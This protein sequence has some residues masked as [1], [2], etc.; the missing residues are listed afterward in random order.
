[1]AIYAEDKYR[2][3]IGFNSECPITPSEFSTW[4]KNLKVFLGPLKDYLEKS[5]SEIVSVEFIIQKPHLFQEFTNL[6]NNP[7][8]FPGPDRLASS[9]YRPLYMDWVIGN[10]RQVAFN[11]KEGLAYKFLREIIA[12]CEENRAKVWKILCDTCHKFYGDIL[13]QT[14]GDAALAFTMMEAR[15]ALTGDAM[16]ATI[17]ARNELR[18]LK[19]ASDGD[20]MENLTQFSTR[21]KQLMSHIATLEGRLFQEKEMIIQF[22]EGLPSDLANVVNEY[23]LL[24][25]NVTFSD[26][27]QRL[28]GF[29]RNAELRKP[30][31]ETPL[32]FLSNQQQQNEQ[33]KPNWKLPRDQDNG[34]GKEFK[35]KMKRKF[36][37]NDNR[38]FQ[39]HR[40]YHNNHHYHRDYHQGHQSFKPK[41]K[42]QHDNRFRND[43]RNGNPRY[44]NGPIGKFKPFPRRTKMR[45]PLRAAANRVQSLEIKYCNI[46]DTNSHD[47]EHCRY[48]L[49]RE[50]VNNNLN[51]CYLDSFANY[52]HKTGEVDKVDEDRFNFVLDSGSTDTHTNNLENLS[53]IKQVKLP[54]ATANGE[55]EYSTAIGEVNSLKDVRYTPSFKENLLSINSLIDLD[56]QVIFS[57]SGSYA[58]LKNGDDI[59]RNVPIKRYNKLYYID[60]RDL[61]DNQSKALL[62]STKPMNNILTWHQRLH[63]SNDLIF[64]L[65]EHHATGINLK[66]KKLNKQLFG[67]ISVCEAC[68]LARIRKKVHKHK[69]RRTFPSKCLE[70]IDVDLKQVKV[71]YAGYKYIMAMKCARSKFTWIFFLKTKDEAV[72]KLEYFKAYVLTKFVEDP[73]KTEVLFRVRQI[74]TDGGGEFEKEFKDACL[75]Y[76]IAHI[77]VPAYSQYL[78]SY[79]ESYWRTLMELTR[80]FLKHAD[81]SDFYWPWACLYA[82]HILNRCLLHPIDKEVKTSYE[83]LY[84]VKPDLSKIRTFGCEIYRHVPLEKRDNKALSDWGEKGKFFG[85]CDNMV[86]GIFVLTPQNAVVEENYDF[87]VF[88]EIIMPRFHINNGKDISELLAEDVDKDM[89]EDKAEAEAEK[90][91]VVK[92]RKRISR[93]R[94][95]E[96]VRKSRRLI[97]KNR[98]NNAKDI[99][100]NLNDVDISEIKRILSKAEYYLLRK[101]VKRELTAE[102]IWQWLQAIGKEKA[103]IA[104]NNVFELVMRPTNGTKIHGTDW[105]FDIKQDPVSLLELFK[106]ARL[107]F[108]GDR[109]KEGIDYFHTFA[110]VAKLSSLRIFLAIVVEF[111]MEM[112][113]GDVRTAFLNAGLEEELFLEIPLFYSIDEFINVLEDNDPLKKVHPSQ[114][115]LKLKKA[116]YGLK[117]APRNWFENIVNFILQLGFNACTAEPCLFYKIIGGDRIIIFLYV[118]DFIIAATNGHHLL[119]Y[120][121]MIANRYDIKEIGKPKKILGISIQYEGKDI[122]INQEDKITKLAEKFEVADIKDEFGNFIKQLRPILTPLDSKIKICKDMI[123]SKKIPKKFQDYTKQMIQELYRSLIGSVNHFNV[124]TRPDIAYAVS[125]FSKYLNCPTIFH[126]LLA[127]RLVR[128]LYTTRRCG[129]R[130]SKSGMKFPTLVNKSYTDSDW[131]AEVDG[132]RSQS[133]IVITL[134]NSPIH[135]ASLTQHIVTISSAEAEIIALKQGAKDTIWIRNIIQELVKDCITMP[136]TEINVDNSS[137]I[138]IVINPMISKKNRHMEIAFYFIV[139]HIQ[140]GTIKVVKIKGELNKADMFTKVMKS[141]YNDLKTKGLLDLRGIDFEQIL[142]IWYEEKKKN[143]ENLEIEEEN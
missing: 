112:W 3:L 23:V 18:Q 103:S 34:N 66:Y 128:Y 140:A 67:K 17:M 38:N 21:L 96:G 68:A 44:F 27:L 107:V 105:R 98:S 46:C 110:P 100:Q 97:E 126:L 47:T 77:I 29:I 122:I 37:K 132:R 133:G 123:L 51:G 135:W 119:K 73:D 9:D 28:I 57:R 102:E 141:F 101:Y 70:E 89:E 109:T 14:D 134:N 72:Q 32:A 6:I 71:G 13:E 127:I 108:R 48:R 99:S 53:N 15:N 62:G 78:N 116:L 142:A 139:Q 75:K 43:P 90:E 137:S 82:N 12:K 81:I 87:T 85:F 35:G 54:V 2:Q 95:E 36:F 125:I 79:V 138:K 91:K 129:I 115:C 74:K 5:F 24:N 55:M 49:A 56:Y 33:V 117:Q 42:R 4:A 61:K 39:H 124:G 22:M 19:M 52:C 80:T 106:K 59:I 76:G 120:R 121:S 10:P 84:G 1:M 50:Y 41:F 8:L 20:R 93:K 143:N 113:Q 65:A 136:A 130:F 16:A 7:N 60:I 104:M 31:A 64:K 40:H 86:H 114:L 30:T 58:I 131:A 45:A 88:N 11:G 92:K 63:L 111:E 118:D 25:Q 26:M 83:W 94:D 69:E